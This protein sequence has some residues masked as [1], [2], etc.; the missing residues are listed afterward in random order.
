MF[1]GTPTPVASPT[2]Y[3]YANCYVDSTQARQF[4]GPYNASVTSIEGCSSF[5]ATYPGGSYPVGPYNYFGVEY[6]TQCYCGNTIANASALSSGCTYACTGA[7][8]EICGGSSA[9][10]VYYDPALV[11][12]P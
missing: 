8:N 3:A 5:C 4:N 9:I 12:H 7:T 11:S 1:T 6:Y 2:P 10:S